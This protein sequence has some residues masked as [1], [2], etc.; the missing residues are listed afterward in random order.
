MYG[1]ARSNVTGESVCN[2]DTAVYPCCFSFKCVAPPGEE[3]GECLP[4]L[5]HEAVV[6]LRHRVLDLIP[7]DPSA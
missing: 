1:L 4:V 7:G 6:L 2:S 5:L 3:L